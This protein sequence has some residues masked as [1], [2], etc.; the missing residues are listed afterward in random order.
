MRLCVDFS[1]YLTFCSRKKESMRKCISWML[2]G[3]LDLVHSIVIV[4]YCFFDCFE[5]RF[6]MR[7]DTKP[8]HY[9]CKS[10]KATI[11][12]ATGFGDMYI[13]EGSCCV[14]AVTES[15]AFE[16]FV[17]MLE[18]LLLR[19]GRGLLFRSSFNSWRMVVLGS[20]FYGCRIRFW[21]WVN[22]SWKVYGG[23]LQPH[24][25]SVQIYQERIC[26]ML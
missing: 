26:N 1:T 12:F 5:R 16:V 23:K 8:L 3:V 13:E 9:V 22:Q 17:Y 15:S 19:L 6:C 25:N 21:G 10:T 14:V 20:I 24:P 7:I 4:D 18:E 2:H 11:A